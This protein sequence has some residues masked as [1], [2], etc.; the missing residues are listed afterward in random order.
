MAE[1]ILDLQFCLFVVDERPVCLWD[2][3]IRRQNTKFLDRLD[4]SYFDYL[5]GIHAHVVNNA[6]DLTG[7]D[8][9]HSA[10]AMRTAYS[11]ALETL[12]ALLGAAI[13]AYWCVPGWI[14]A[15]T[16]AELYSLIGKIQNN[17][18][19]MSA[20]EQES[21]GWCDVF[22][23][24]F[25]SLAS[26]DEQYAATM[27]EDF[28]KSWTYLAEDFLDEAFAREFNS[29]KHGLR[30][31]S[32]GFKF[33][34]GIPD[35]PGVVPPE[36]AMVDVSVSD[37]GSSYFRSQKIGEPKCHIS[38]RDEW[39]NW[40]LESIAWG[41]RR[42]ALS[43]KNIQSALRAINDSTSELQFITPQVGDFEQWRGFFTMGEPKR[44]ISPEYIDF[45]D[46]NNMLANYNSKQY[47]GT[48]RLIFGSSDD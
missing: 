8:V 12:F 18:P 37:F 3:D 14:N 25:S 36:E 11:Q 47:L 24:L 7:K 39:R 15:Y 22:H 40:D 43:I 41:L 2:E 46:K 1:Q 6:T 26:V 45:F 44:P 9:Q 30:V 33:R 17:L 23:F 21:P 5:Y 20:L 42:A 16:N 13:Q 31:G 48:K 19:V 4:S 27:E 28:A 38:M 29:I 35:E 34:I 10:L 32:G